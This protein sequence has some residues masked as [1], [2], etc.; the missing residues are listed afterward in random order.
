MILRDTDK[1]RFSSGLNFLLILLIFPGLTFYAQTKVSLKISGNKNFTQSDYRKWAN[2]S[3]LNINSKSAADSIKKRIILNLKENGCFFSSVKIDSLKFDKDSASAQIYLNVNEGKKAYLTSIV[4]SAPDSLDSAFVYSRLS[5]PVN[6]VFIPKL[7]EAELN[8]ILEEYS[9]RGFPFAQFRILNI[10]FPD[11]D[12]VRIYLKF[13]LGVPAV[14]DKI[15]ISGNEKTKDYVIERNIRIKP[16]EKYSESRIKRIPAALKKLDFFKSVSKPEFYFDSRKRGVLSIKVVEKSTNYFDGIVGYIPKSGNRNG[17]FTGSV[18]INLRN[19]FGTE[20]AFGFKWEKTDERSQ[21]FEVGYLEPWIFGLPVNISGM[22]DQKTQDTTYIKRNYSIKINYLAT[23]N[24]TA[25]LIYSYGET[26]P[27]GDT[28]K[29][30]V[31]HSSFS[32]SGLEFLYDNRDDYYVP[33]KGFYV[34]LG[35]RFSRKTILGPAKFVSTGKTGNEN[36][37]KGEAAAG[38]YLSPVSRNVIALAFHYKEIKGTNL[39]VSDLYRFGGTNTLRGFRFEQFL[40]NKIGWTNFEYR[41]LLSSDTYGFLFVDGGYYYNSILKKENNA[42]F[43]KL[44]YGYG[45]GLNFAT[46]LGNM[47]ISFALGEGDSFS[48]GKL[49]FGIVNRF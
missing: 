13:E 29:F 34:S 8:G 26:I 37:F 31:F 11:S 45:L 36:Y 40:G 4:L 49:H 25:G 18:K 23:E 38:I 3:S 42:D 19:L 15:E 48:E 35:L 20:R 39:E 2:L 10:S 33:T 9:E 21:Y 12:K 44:T 24:L 43:R 47:K 22:I 17:Y 14:I 46:G 27:T 30:T 16:G 6:A 32:S 41:Y 5:E 28:S 1:T 7:F